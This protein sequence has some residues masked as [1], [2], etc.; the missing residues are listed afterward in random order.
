MTILKKKHTQNKNQI[1]L[2]FGFIIAALMDLLNV[3]IDLIRKKILMFLGWNLLIR[4]SFYMS[5]TFVK[6]KELDH[7]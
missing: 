1:S 2:G 4:K 3:N 5:V 7:A 6:N